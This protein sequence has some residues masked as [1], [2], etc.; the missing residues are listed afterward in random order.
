MRRGDKKVDR[1][2]QGMERAAATQDVLHV[3]PRAQDRDKQLQQH[4][5]VRRLRQR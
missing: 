4:W 1:V 3:I 5:Q 2:L